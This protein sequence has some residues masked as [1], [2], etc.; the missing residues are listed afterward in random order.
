MSKLS[1]VFIHTLRNPFLKT[2]FYCLYIQNLST[3]Q[4]KKNNI[5]FSLFP[6][7]Y[8]LG[9]TD[10]GAT[11]VIYAVRRFH[12]TEYKEHSPQSHLA[13]HITKHLT[14]HRRSPTVSKSSFLPIFFRISALLF[15]ESLGFSLLWHKMLT[16]VMKRSSCFSAILS[17]EGRV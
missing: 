17:L 1:K 14:D 10:F 2:S 8:G 16:V 15:F 3:H 6:A 12:C 4:P 7:F 9:K 11:I 13:N 5:Q